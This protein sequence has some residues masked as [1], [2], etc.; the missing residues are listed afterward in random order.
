MTLGER[1]RYYERMGLDQSVLNE[2]KNRILSVTM[3]R[4][5]I[6]F[7]SAAKGTMTPDSDIDIL[8]LEDHPVSLRREGVRIGNALRGLG[9]PFDIVVMSTERFEETKPV[10]GGLAYPANKGGIVIYEAA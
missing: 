3:P 2:I 7:G 6:L 8:V 5:V 9:Y 10:I 4:R 1:S